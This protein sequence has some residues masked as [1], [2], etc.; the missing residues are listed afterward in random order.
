MATYQV[1]NYNPSQNTY[2]PG[3]AE[4]VVSPGARYSFQNTDTA[5]EMDP[6]AAHGE[7]ALTAVR[8][9]KTTPI[10]SPPYYPAEEYLRSS[11]QPEYL[12]L[13]IG[14][15]VLIYVG[16]FLAAFLLAFLI[17]GMRSRNP[18]M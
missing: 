6:L 2:T 9:P 4:E 8:A 13:E 7:I 3:D 10:S 1:L 16:I 12:R 15:N 17:A 18:F 14:K 11:Y 5:N